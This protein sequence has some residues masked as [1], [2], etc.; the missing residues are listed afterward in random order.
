[1][2]KQ[3]V[4]GDHRLAV[5]HGRMDEAQD[6]QEV[7]EHHPKIMP[8]GGAEPCLDEFCTPTGRGSSSR[9]KKAEAAL[10]IGEFKGSAQR[11]V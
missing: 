8:H 5:T 1:M 11:A 2:A 7:F 10:R 9:A 6:E 3:Q 4:F